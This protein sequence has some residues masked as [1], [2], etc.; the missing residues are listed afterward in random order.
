VVQLGAITEYVDKKPGDDLA[1]AGP[2]IEVLRKNNQRCSTKMSAHR[3]HPAAKY[4]I[5]VAEPYECCATLLDQRPKLVAHLLAW[6]L[7]FFETLLQGVN[8]IH[9]RAYLRERCCNVRPP[10]SN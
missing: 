8:V 5:V 1:P 7:R 6:R 4:L 2:V 3:S 10:E 9:L